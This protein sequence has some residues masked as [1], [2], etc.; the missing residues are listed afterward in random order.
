M[1]GNVLPLGL[2][3]S[4]GVGLGLCYFGGLWWTVRQLATAR[5]PALWL[6]GSFV[7]R[8]GVSLVGFYVVLS[9][10]AARLMVCLLG[11]FVARTILVR[12]WLPAPAKSVAQEEP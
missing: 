5:H 7:V 1:T 3:F 2:A 10:G 12:R 8:A 6:M 9:G 11:F 4:V